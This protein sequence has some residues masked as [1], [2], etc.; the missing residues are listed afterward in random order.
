MKTNGR[1]NVFY[2]L[3]TLIGTII[4]AGIFGLPYVFSRAGFPIGL[5]FLFVLGFI[6]TL[7][8]LMF[9]EVILRTKGKHRIVGLAKLYFGGKW[10]RVCAVIVFLGLYSSLLAYIILGG[11]FL[12][13]LFGGENEILPFLLFFFFGSVFVFLGVRSISE[14]EL[15]MSLALVG[16]IALFFIRGLPHISLSYF[17]GVD[18]RHAF[19]PYGVVLFSL[20]GMAAIPELPEILGSSRLRSFFPVIVWGTVIPIALY[21]LFVWSVVGVTGRETSPEAIAELVPY[22]GKS[23]VVMGAVFGL[24]AVFSSF[25]V[26]GVN[27]RDTFMYDYHIPRF[28]SWALTV[29]IPALLF[30]AGV[31][32]FIPVMGFAGGVAGGLASIIIVLLHSSAAK[33]GENKPVYRIFLPSW[34]KVVLVTLFVLG[35]VIE[36]LFV[37]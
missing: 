4:G 18:L 2:A 32:G 29:G 19:L 10:A 34:A 24:L 26:L 21:V 9:G 8:H 6:T 7:L 11:T 28:V 13:L 16:I 37:L 27:L 17:F 20:A 35:I 3:A 36:T 33:H 25:L 31:K 1:R 30:L 15:V 23:I 22:L 14:V 5:L 12:S